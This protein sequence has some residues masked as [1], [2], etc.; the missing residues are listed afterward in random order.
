MEDF[1]S[2]DVIV[3][4]SSAISFPHLIDDVTKPH[5]SDYGTGFWVLDYQRHL[6]D[7]SRNDWGGCGTIQFVKIPGMRT[8]IKNDASDFFLRNRIEM[9]L[10]NAPN[11]LR[12]L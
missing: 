2:R 10:G 3:F 11:S 7:S 4:S 1:R 5:S 9:I 6:C 12:R 8:K